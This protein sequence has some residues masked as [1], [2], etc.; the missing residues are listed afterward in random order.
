MDAS[1]SRGCTSGKPSHSSGA[2]GEIFGSVLG[3][4]LG[5]IVGGPVGGA[6]GGTLGTF[7]GE[8][9]ETI[10]KNPSY[11]FKSYGDWAKCSSVCLK[12]KD[13]KCFT[14]C[15]RGERDR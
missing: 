4:V 6:V 5:S 11:G 13:K 14:K 9:V 12:S 1:Y 10:V 8:G 2:I 15:L 3:G 7:A